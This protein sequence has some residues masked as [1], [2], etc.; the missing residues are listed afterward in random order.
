MNITSQMVKE[1]REKTGV[2]MME[3]KRALEE[4]TGSFDKAIDLLRTKGIA[5]AQKKS[6]RVTG[7]GIISSYIHQGGKIG[8]LLQLNCETDFVAR[9]DDFQ[10]LAKDICMQIAAANPPYLKKED[11]PS[12]VIEKEKG[13]YKAQMVSSGKPEKVLDKIVEGKLEKYYTEVCLLNQPFIKDGNKSIQDLLTEKIA[14]L[15]ENINVGGF[16]RFKVG[17]VYGAKA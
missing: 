17:E 10:E 7:Q 1:L 6:G 16:V 8:V 11:V 13:I 14:K 2:S 3:C 15:G 5:V 12:D 4:A 9:T